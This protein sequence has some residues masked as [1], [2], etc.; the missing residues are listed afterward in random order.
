MTRVKR[1]KKAKAK[2]DAR[3]KR[4]QDQARHEREAF[5]KKL[6]TARE[7]AKTTPAEGIVEDDET[8]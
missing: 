7:A 4:A 2:N 6:D 8:S 3:V 1:E 5:A